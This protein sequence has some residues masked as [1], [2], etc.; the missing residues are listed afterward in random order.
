MINKTMLFLFV[1]F[2][3]IC[4]LY[5]EIIHDSDIT[6]N[7]T[8]YSDDNPHIIPVDIDV[9]SGVTLT[10]SAGCIVKISSSKSI[11]ISGSLH[12]N[13]A[14]SNEISFEYNGESG[15]WN[16]L[17]IGSNGQ[18]DFSYCVFQNSTRGIY[19]YNADNISADNC[20][21]INNNYGSWIHNTDLSITNC[22]YES[23]NTGILLENAT[24][25][26][27]GGNNLFSGNTTGVFIRNSSD[28]SVGLQQSFTENEKGLR[29]NNCQ[30]PVIAAG[31][32][33]TNN[34]ESGLSFED[35]TGL[36]TLDNF[37]FSGN[38]DY[39]ALLI[40]NS[41]DFLISAS[42]TNTGN[43]WPLTID[44]GSF[45]DP[46][47]NIPTTGN[48]NNN[49][50]VTSGYSDNTGIWPHF[51]DLNYIVTETP[52]I[53]VSGGLTVADG[54]TIKFNSSR[55]LTINGN[56]IAP[57]VARNGINFEYNGDSG[58][59][60]Y[61]YFGNNGQGNFS[62]CTFKNSSRGIYAYSAEIVTVENCTFL[63]NN[64]GSWIYDTTIDYT[65]NTFSNN[66]KGVYL[67][68]CISSFIGAD[69]EF[70][71]NATGIHIKN[72]TD[73]TIALQQPFSENDK[74]IKL[75]DCS[76]PVIADGNSFI[77]NNEYGLCFEDCTGLGSLNNYSFTDNEGYGALLIKNS[78][79]FLIGAS[80]TNTGNE[81]PLT[82]D[83]GSF[84]DP[85]SSIPT[86]GNT[87]NDIRVTSG[88]S[89]KSGTW[90]DFAD[91]DYIITENPIIEIDGSLTIAGGNTLKFNNSKSFTIHGIFNA[92]GAARNGID[93]INNET[94]GTWN[95][96]FFGSN[97]QGDFSYCT[98]K[99]SSRG[100]YAYEA[101]NVAAENCSFHLNDRASWINNTTIDFTDNTFFYNETALFLDNCISPVI[102][103]GND[104]H[105]NTNG[106]H[107]KNSSNPVIELLEPVY[108][109]DIG[110][111]LQN[112][113]NPV[114]SAGISI[115]DNTECGLKF[116]DC[117]GLGTLNN[118]TFTD[119]GEYG[120]LVI[121]NSG[122]FLIGALVTTTDNEWPLTIDAG[123]F[124]DPASNIPT[125]GNNNND[126]R[127]TSGFSDNNGTWPY[128]TDLN[129]IVTETP[130]IEVSGGLTVAD[131][132]TI[133]FNYNKS[134]SC[135]G[136]FVADGSA[137]SGINFLLNDFSNWNYIYISA[138]GTGNFSHCYFQNSSRG[139]YGYNCNSIQ[140]DHCTFQDNDYGSWLHNTTIDLTYCTYQGNNV[141][142]LVEDCVS[143]VVGL[144]NH[145]NNNTTGIFIRNS[146][147]PSIEL[148]EPINENGVG[149]YL[150]NCQDPVIAAGN[151][152][153]N[154]T[155]CGIKFLD[156]S[157]LNTLDELT[158]TGNLEYGS[159]MILNSGDFL[160]GSSLIN[161]GNEWPL[162]IDT[163]S[164]PEASSSIPTTG[165]TNNDIRVTSNTTNKTGSWHYFDGLDYVVTD[166]PDIETG[167]MLTISDGNTLRFYIGKSIS[168]GGTLNAVGAARN[169]IDFIGNEGV[170]WNYVYISQGGE[171]D[172][173]YCT[174]ENSF[175]G[176]Y[177]YNAGLV[178]IDHCSFNVNDKG[179]HIT[180]CDWNFTNCCF[181]G[182]NT[183]I[184]IADCSPLIHNCEII[185]NTDN[186]M[187][188]DDSAIPDLGTVIS[189]GNDIYG[190]GIYNIYNGDEN[191]SAAFTYWGMDYPS[192]IEY[193]IYDFYDNENLGIVEFEPWSNASHT[194]E[195]SLGTSPE[196]LYIHYNLGS[197][198]LDWTDS[199]DA[200]YYVVLTSPI[201]Y[202]ENQF[203]Q[204]AATEIYTTTWSKVP[205]E[206][207]EYFSVVSIIAE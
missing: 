157:G 171:G 106:I 25:P 51:T 194:L 160:L 189:E 191:I 170:S 54:N 69:N 21:F 31:N 86:S 190:N 130:N 12:A 47:S 174:F 135:E 98:I 89:Y 134:I 105:S 15:T 59:W 146:S 83:A 17:F 84:P 64:N 198:V 114:I 40:K 187:R 175:Q 119:N 165:N 140:A 13:G 197:I 14:V 75:E 115:T 58:T 180:G 27:L 9:N 99:N 142:L 73:P 62:Y 199:P 120:A 177:G 76:N 82:I 182:N 39:G 136:N 45:P 92:F 19:A 151:S 158:F 144:G 77:D 100:I 139:I 145:F 104:F 18:G 72:S 78:G 196:N 126:I 24:S 48:N 26:S 167:S 168:C 181:E 35:C 183:G 207:K 111:Y 46:A 65:G 66:G 74:G 125:A 85:A 81:W 201:P 122:D 32:T 176:L 33:F 49:I 193:T 91:L 143:P 173:S 2:L 80:V 161:T 163:G 128:F 23:N 95:Y 71:L 129:Y 102:G 137:R 61:L 7:E 108:G 16:Y 10:I 4:N 178:T 50:R 162:T 188:L 70:V 6:S 148:L 5:S 94:G 101:D 112:C 20:S 88:N 131:G 79:D 28:P 179:S 56:F 150:R 3:L 87:N 117:T 41:G 204:E 44:A 200:T 30:D 133:K 60:N 42:V 43:E 63:F 22:T 55:S 172:F 38:E 113:Q 121:K 159:L 184:Y 186:G 206:T 164:F 67:E 8:W 90:P 109:N 123:S 192:G 202:I 169:G 37:T 138:G 147:D 156:C 107:V 11:L 185:N 52:N 195:L 29:F 166:S 127:V 155:G 154:S 93:F 124:P 152:F 103:A 96:L 97:G 68:N 118:L 53:E 34:T 149:I 1:S 132:N 116:V 110:I 141:G 57:G 153:T 205:T 36:G 203:W